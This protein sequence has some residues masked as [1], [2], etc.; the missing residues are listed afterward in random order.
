MEID[1]SQVWTALQ[2]THRETL[3]EYAEGAMQVAGDDDQLLIYLPRFKAADMKA[4]R[5]AIKGSQAVIV[6]SWQPEL[7]RQRLRDELHVQVEAVPES[8]ARRFGMRV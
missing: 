3:S 8:L 1:H 5:K 6:Y 4:L 7:V 2:L